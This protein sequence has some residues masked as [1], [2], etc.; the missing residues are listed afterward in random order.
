MMKSDFFKLL[1][2][3]CVGVLTVVGTATASQSQ[4][5]EWKRY[6]N[7]S[8]GKRYI[9]AQTKGKGALAAGRY[10]TPRLEGFVPIPAS[11]GVNEQ[12]DEQNG[13]DEGEESNKAGISSAS[14]SSSSSG[15]ESPAKKKDG[16]AVQGVY[17]RH[18]STVTQ[19]DG[20]AVLDTS[21]ATFKPC[22]TFYTGEA[23]IETLLQNSAGSI[24]TWAARLLASA[25]LLDELWKDRANIRYKTAGSSWVGTE[26][27][28]EIKK[29]AMDYSYCANE[30]LRRLTDAARNT[31]N[32]K[33]YVWQMINAAVGMWWNDETL[34]GDYERYQEEQYNGTTMTPVGDNQLRMQ[35]VRWES[36]IE[37]CTE[38]TQ[39][40]ELTASLSTRMAETATIRN[41]NTI[42]NQTDGDIVLAE[43]ADFRKG[44]NSDGKGQLNRKSTELAYKVLQGVRAERTRRK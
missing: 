8:A 5:E 26:I 12:T 36:M 25:V 7:S 6:W 21:E 15:S 39:A 3:S 30:I 23:Q 31:G 24:D 10:A 14:S 28:E 19:K 44:L 22:M 18:Y 38:M 11:E 37:K 42:I 13:Q 40:R 1:A 33:P 34:L 41:N 17:T 32:I 4:N 16:N 43:A 20:K 9:E 27:S 2:Y 29:Q 35:K